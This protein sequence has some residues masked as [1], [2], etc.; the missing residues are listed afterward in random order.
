MALAFDWERERGLSGNAAYGLAWM[1]RELALAGRYDEAEQCVARA[2]EHPAHSPIAEAHWRQGAA[3]VHAH[4]GEQAEAE[5]LASEAVAKTRMTDSP[6]RQA[7]AF[8]DLAEVL[9][10][11]GRREDALAAWQEAL[12][13][14]E[15]KG[16]IPLARRVRERLAAL[17]PV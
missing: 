15:R 17:D 12:D 7:D 6:R 11:A 2:Q 4:R 9:E 3:L 16:V 14:Y 13:R 1:S 8:C 5:R 10:V